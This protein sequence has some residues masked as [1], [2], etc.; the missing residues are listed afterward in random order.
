ML[1]EK[2]RCYSEQLLYRFALEA[3]NYD[4]GTAEPVA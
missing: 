4:A 2:D 3:K 1:S